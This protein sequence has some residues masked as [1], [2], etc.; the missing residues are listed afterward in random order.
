[1]KSQPF[2]CASTARIGDS[3]AKMAPPSKDRPSRKEKSRATD[4]DDHFSQRPRS[5]TTSST[6]AEPSRS[7]PPPP[8]HPIESPSLF[9]PPQSPRP[10]PHRQS[11]RSSRLHR[12]DSRES[13]GTARISSTSAIPTLSFMRSPLN[14]S[15]K[16]SKHPKPKTKSP[17]KRDHTTHPLNNYRPSDQPGRLRVGQMSSEI[18][19]GDLMDVDDRGEPSSSS[20][21]PSSPTISNS[22][23]GASNENEHEQDQG[24]SPAP[25][26]HR[27]PP[28]P[29]NEAPPKP[30]VDAEACKAAGNKFFKAQDYT[31]AIT[32]YSKGKLKILQS[33]M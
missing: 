30:A 22:V 6:A 12:E 13:P 10:P 5:N 14:L 19:D 20:S 26:P 17:P 4:K 9:P 15:G 8:P 3:G 32:E 7:P 2:E 1:M 16:K 24:A 25:P 11:P 21:V 23:N 29:R 28:S 31:R 18:G 33:W 27:I